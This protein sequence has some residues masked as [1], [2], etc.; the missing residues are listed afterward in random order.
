MYLR[1]HAS[2]S[3]PSKGELK[4]RVVRRSGCPKKIVEALNKLTGVEGVGTK[5]PHLQGDKI[6][7]SMK[8][9][10]DIPIGDVGDSHRLDK[11]NFS[12]R[13]ERIKSTTTSLVSLEGP[14]E[15]PEANT[16]QHVTIAFESD[17]DTCKWHTAR[18]R[19]KL[20]AKCQAQ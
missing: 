8:R 1:G 17:Y 11:I 19:Y 13:H 3:T 2:R 4:L 12:Q 14:S 10:L 5:V 20:N 15:Q 16:S 6:F 7:G 18:I 9:N